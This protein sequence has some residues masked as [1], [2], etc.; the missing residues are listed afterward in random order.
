M[1]LRICLG[2]YTNDY[3][4]YARMCATTDLTIKQQKHKKVH[5]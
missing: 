3:Y 5:Q 4:I 2:V 1:Q